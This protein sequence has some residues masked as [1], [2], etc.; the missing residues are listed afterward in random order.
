NGLFTG[1]SLGN[2][3]NSTTTDYYD[4]RRIVN[5]TD[6]AQD[7]ADAA[8]KLEGI[9]NRSLS[10]FNSVPPSAPYSF[11]ITTASASQLN[12]SWQLNA[13]NA[14]GIRIRRWNSYN[15][16]TTITTLG[17]GV[18]SYTDTGLQG[19]TGYYYQA[20]A[21]NAAGESAAVYAFGTT[22][23]TITVPAAPYSF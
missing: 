12:L 9:L 17:A 5:G 16:Y 8:T 15:G 11:T 21:Y 2:Y 6:H 13:S 19:A 1:K 14:D 22:Q 3:I 7:I 23:A 18:R 20:V 4:A 10:T